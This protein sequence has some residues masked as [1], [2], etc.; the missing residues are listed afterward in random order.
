M[1]VGQA[2]VFDRPMARLNGIAN[3]LMPKLRHER[4]GCKCK[5]LVSPLQET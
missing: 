2:H 3:D 4:V 1:H 5:A